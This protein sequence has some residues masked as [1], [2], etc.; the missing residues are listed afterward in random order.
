MTAAQ[1][2][3]RFLG[4]AVRPPFGSA[5]QADRPLPAAPG[6]AIRQRT[7][8]AQT[9]GCPHAPAQAQQPVRQAAHRRAR[10]PRSSPDCRAR[11]A[12]P[13]PGSATFLMGIAR[14]RS[15]ELLASAATATRPASAPAVHAFV[16][17]LA[18]RRRSTERSQISGL[19]WTA[20]PQLT[21]LPRPAMSMRL[22]GRHGR[23]NSVTGLPAARAQQSAH[24]RAAA[25]RWSSILGDPS[26][27][28][29]GLT[30]RQTSGHRTACAGDLASAAGA[31]PAHGDAMSQPVADL[32]GVDARHL[33]R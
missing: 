9:A 3:H 10:A 31:T 19:N 21:G 26:A 13:R 25:G 5:E 27:R 28:D 18:Q 7:R 14:L 2:R 30:T 6:K 20:T 23:A 29:L 17:P 11:P 1:A 33:G 32:A 15:T 4:L 8:L 24:G 12:R 22:I 16:G